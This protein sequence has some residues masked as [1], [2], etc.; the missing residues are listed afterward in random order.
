[1]RQKFSIRKPL[2]AVL[3]LVLVSIA[4]A[5]RADEIAL[6]PDVPDRY[7]VKK[8]DTLWGIA[9]RF[10]RDPWRWPEIWRINR[11]E[12]KNPHWIYPGDVVVFL[13]GAP[14]ATPPRPP[15]LV[16]ERQTVRVSPTVRAT[17]LD[18]DAI[19]SIPPGDIEPYLTRPLVTGPDGLWDA[20]EIV[21]GR[22]G[23]VVRG[24]G[25]FVYVAGV[26]PK[27]GDALTIYR[28][29][30]ALV[31]LDD[32]PVVLGYEQIYLGT[33]K[34]ERFGDVSTV[35][36]TKALE[37][38]LVGD[39]LVPT[40][41]EQIV[42]YVPHAPEQP[43][44]GRILR[45]ARDGSEAGRGMIVTLD[46]GTEDGVDVGTVLAIDRVFGSIPDPRASRQVD[47]VLYFLGDFRLTLPTER[48]GLL[49]VFR[50]FD[51]VSYAIL[52]NTAYPVLA[53]DA[54]RNP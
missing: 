14:D 1:M 19:A 23:R 29:G 52:L 26:N 51:R 35:R 54:V 44:A 50:V 9:Q 8:G 20:A 11:A 42:N 16:L 17:P 40:P 38:I 53:G 36:I 12:I 3:A 41:R 6:A 34:V 49:F 25:D 46:R 5:V 28:P 39:R 37:E 31:S 24:E 45:I 47:P 43:V 27:A 7:V 15:Q 30:S 13:R 2:V 22:D 10:L 32:P 48:I 33:A 4:G 18:V 21:A